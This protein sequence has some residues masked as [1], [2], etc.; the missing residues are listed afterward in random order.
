M[1]T[2]LTLIAASAAA[3]A[4]SGCIAV[5]HT[6]HREH[7]WSGENAEPFDGALAACEAA[8]SLPRD[9]DACMAAK[10]WTRK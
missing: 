7:G 2:I 1:K 9:I 3:L 5:S 8:H 6:T 10:G 4:A